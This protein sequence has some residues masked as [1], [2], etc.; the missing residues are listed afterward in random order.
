MTKFYLT[1]CA[2]ISNSIFSNGNIL[3]KPPF[4][5]DGHIYVYI[6]I[7]YIYVYIYIIYIYIYVSVISRN[8]TL[9]RIMLLRKWPIKFT[10]RKSLFFRRA[11]VETSSYWWEIVAYSLLAKGRNAKKRKAIKP[12]AHV[13]TP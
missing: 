11:K 5:V 8:C 12:I 9:A 1:E 10:A 6:Y 3:R 2:R 13:L 4:P 7:L